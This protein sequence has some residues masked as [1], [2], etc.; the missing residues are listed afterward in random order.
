MLF[1]DNKDSV[2]SFIVLS[3]SLSI[4]SHKNN[5]LVIIVASLS[6]D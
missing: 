6:S 2:F 1:M 5:T 3:A 4:L